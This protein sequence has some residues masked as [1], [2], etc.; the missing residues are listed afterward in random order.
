MIEIRPMKT[1]DL[2]FVAELEKKLFS[3]AWSLES[4]GEELCSPFAKSY[5]LSENG[6]PCA[7]GL[8][9]LMAGEGEVL[10]I[11]TSPEHR[12][13]GF[14][15]SLLRRFWED[16]PEK[17]FLEVREGNLPARR[18]YE[19]VGFRMISKRPRYYRDPIEDAVVYEKK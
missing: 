4:L 11:G 19:S 6:T 3:D 13:K 14:A 1:S 8:F 16:A 7:Y 18:L 12:R 9:R 5:L 2:A 10:R 17:T 15:T